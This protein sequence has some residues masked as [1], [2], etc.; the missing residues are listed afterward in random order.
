[1]ANGRPTASPD[2]DPVLPADDNEITRRGL[3]WVI[4]STPDI[5]VCAQVA[6][7]RAAETVDIRMPGMDRLAATEAL[8]TLPR[9]V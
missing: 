9:R 3:A 2:A 8:L 6:D 1:M 5:T 4:D 7:R